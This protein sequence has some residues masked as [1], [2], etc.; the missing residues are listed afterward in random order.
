LVLFAREDDVDGPA[1]ARRWC[2]RRR[3]VGA[4]GLLLGHATPDSP[5]RMIVYNADGSRAEMS[6]NGIRCFAHAL[7]RVA[8]EPGRPDLSERRILT[9]A[10]PRTVTARATEDPST[11]VASVDMGLIREL[12]PPESWSALGA[13]PDRPVLHVGIGNPHAVVAVDDVRAVDLEAIGARVPDVNVE[14]IEPGP[15]TD[16]LTIRVHER[17]VGVTDAC[18][19][20]ACAAAWAAARWRLVRAAA[21]LVVHMDGGA[22]RVVLDQP[23]PGRVTLTGPATFIATIEIPT[24]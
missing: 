19:T 17:G 20:G 16:A 12:P 22:V 6:G 14:V 4:D 23:E 5:A 18:G 21:E 3:G 11:I 8:G 2:D 15:E 7:A 9:D 13:H 24:S 1:L 10:G